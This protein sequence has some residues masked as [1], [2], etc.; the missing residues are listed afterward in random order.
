[1]IRQATTEIHFHKD[2]SASCLTQTSSTGKDAIVDELLLWACFANH[3]INNLGKDSSFLVSTLVGTPAGGLVAIMDRD[4]SGPRLRGDHPGPG[5]KTFMA[6]MQPAASQQIESESDLILV[7]ENK[8]RPVAFT[9]NFR[10]FGLLG[11]NLDYYIPASVLL[12]WR[13][14]AKQRFQDQ[15]YIACLE[16]LGRTCGGC[17]QAGELNLRNGPSL[18]LIAVL[19]VLRDYAS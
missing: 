15:A 12:L 3:Q 19:A 6:T 16:E 10:G 14:L 1:M 7:R 18:A 4:G 9:V 8:K 11:R 5:S 13:H 17:V 2:G